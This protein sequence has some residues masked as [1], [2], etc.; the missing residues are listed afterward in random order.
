LSKSGNQG[1]PNPS[2]G[3]FVVG[4]KISPKFR[5]PSGSPN[6]SL[7]L[8]VVGKKFLSIGFLSNIGKTLY[9]FL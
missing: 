4:K 9:I 5:E 6:P 7:G 3:L 1:S 2:F 8:F